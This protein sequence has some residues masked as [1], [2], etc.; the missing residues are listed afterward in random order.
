MVVG[1]G[2]G[3][4]SAALLLM[5]CVSAF[6][7]KRQ[8]RVLLQQMEL[9]HSQ[10]KGRLEEQLSEVRMSAQLTKQQREAL[11]QQLDA[12][13][14]K[15]E[16]SRID[17]AQLKISTEIGQGSFGTVSRGFYQGTPCAIKKL[18]P[19]RLTQQAL[20]D[21]KHEVELNLTLR[22]PNVIQMIG[23]SW[24]VESGIVCI[25]MELAVNGTL[26][27]MLSDRSNES[28]MGQERV[29]IALGVARAM[30]Y[31]HGMGIIHRDLK[32]ENVLMAEAMTPKVADFGVS[33][34]GDD[35]MTMTAVGTP[36]FSSPEILTHSRYSA[37]VDIWSFGCVLACLHHWQVTPY[38]NEPAATLLS[39][40]I[41]GELRPS[42]PSSAPFHTLL[43]DCCGGAFDERCSTFVS[44]CERLET[45][46][47]SYRAVEE[48]GFSLAR[49]P[50]ESSFSMA[51]RQAS[52]RFSH[53]AAS[54]K[55]PAVFWS[56]KRTP[57]KLKAKRWGSAKSLLVQAS[58]TIEAEHSCGG[59]GGPL[60]TLGEKSFPALPLR[61]E[62]VVTRDNRSVTEGEELRM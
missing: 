16:R 50:S 60:H 11:A 49:A 48:Q 35:M 52:P 23:S 21:F 39:R 13:S 34:E 54:S 41:S 62:G 36:L 9:A 20:A 8:K 5:G 38:P 58:L 28:K 24:D 12:I 25:V 2:V 31:L 4:G 42:L 53:S 14:G 56:P 17:V 59:G 29:S 10:E 26:G 32:P 3:L 45:M 40:V 7:W 22:H 6:L 46:R 15:M 33:R 43:R 57:A 61:V 30:A 51:S 37:S 44:A 47:Q 1:L 19:H 18:S 27:A 55:G